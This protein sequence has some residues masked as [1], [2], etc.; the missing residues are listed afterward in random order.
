M[1]SIELTDN[2]RQT[3]RDL[4]KDKKKRGDELSKELGKGASYISQIENGKIKEIDFDLLDN[5]FRKITDLPE[6]Q[7]N[8]FLDNLLDNVN[9]HL[10][11]E[12]IQHEKWI[13]QFN[14]EIRQFPITDSL[15]EVI[16]EE[17]HKLNYTPEEFVNIINQNRG[18]EG[19]ELPEPNKLQI[20]IID[21]GYKGFGVRSSI[22]FELPEDFISKIL[23]KETKTI[24]YINMQGILFNLFLSEGNSNEDAHKKTD[25]LLY[26]NKFYTIQQRNKIIR[27][28]IKEKTEKNEDFTFYDIQ[29]T[30]YDKKYTQ[31]KSDIDGAFN[32]LRDKNI[33]Y[34]C[35]RLEFL[36]K[37]MHEDLG[38]IIALTSTP[39]S[40]INSD[41]RKDFWND[42]QELVKSYVD[43][44]EEN[45]EES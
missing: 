36:S 35:E 32:F 9:S 42:Y 23:S 20:E 13:H 3:I 27:D 14:H 34:A 39:I 8:D 15:I 2:L 21:I 29:P 33:V 38:L 19:M 45:S 12:E 6:K 5:I 37:N 30:D 17:L 25:D 43:K 1:P 7:Y 44:S 10:T 24:S 11:K 26:K 28:A 41:L 16:Q 31:L 4:R 22:R 18:L 40:K